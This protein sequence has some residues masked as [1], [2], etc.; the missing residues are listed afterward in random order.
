MFIKKIKSDGIAHLSYLIG[1]GKSAAVIDPRRD[2]DIY[3][4]E[5]QKE[6]AAIKYI[7]ETHRNEDYVVGSKELALRTGAQILH[8]KALD[9]KYGKGVSDGDKFDLG[10]MAL[11]I[12]ETPGHTFE[13][14]SIVIYDKEIGDKAVGVFTGDALFIGDVGRSDF[15]PSEAEKVAGL[16]Y[17]S[18][19][20][21][22]FPLGEEVL[23]YPA[24]GAGSV[25]GSGMSSRE[26]STLGLEK[27]YNPLF[28]KSREEFIQYKSKEHHYLPPYFKKM[29]DYNQNGAPILHNTPVPES[30]T[31]DKFENYI[32]NGMIAIDV[33]SP[34]AYAGVHIP[35][36]ISLPLNMIPVFA[37]WL[38]PYDQDLGIIVEN[39]SEIQEAV[40][41]LIRL[42]YDQ[43]R[44]VLIKGVQRW[45]VS[46][47]EY[48]YIPNIHVNTLKKR[49]E[50]NE[51]FTLL[52]VRSKEEFESGHLPN[53]LNIYVGELPARLDEIPPARPITAFCGSGRR[54]IIAASIL[55]NNGIKDVENCFGSMEACTAT[56]CEKL[57]T[58]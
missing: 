9:F 52:D 10:S 40:T 33:R 42:G 56:K 4:V 7:F 50:T 39:A 6:G 51:S 25:C 48:N 23:L 26:F 32:K 24:H 19:T 31:V 17:D 2:V 20:E 30:V 34:E 3:I 27:K 45:E 36:T 43:I 58:K 44:A 13:S 18:I 49:I 47:R 55:K 22:I 37:G 14:I 57:I 41:H 8:G 12:M 16:L 35:G 28:Q 15:F 21:K 1:S 54:A 38:L 29:E 46:G 11:A 53:A 5:A